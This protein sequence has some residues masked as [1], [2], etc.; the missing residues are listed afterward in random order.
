MTSVIYASLSAF[1]IVWLSLNVIKKRHFYIISIGGDH[2]DLKGAIAAHSNV[3]EY[4]SAHIL[5]IHSLRP[6]TFYGTHTTCKR[7]VNF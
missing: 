1:L 2:K 6:V 3:I 7:Y 4:N 5:I